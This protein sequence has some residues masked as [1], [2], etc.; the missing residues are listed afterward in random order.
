VDA[1]E[2]ALELLP[3]D[4]RPAALDLVGLASEGGSGGLVDSA[5]L[6]VAVL[7]GQP[8]PWAALGALLGAA[9]WPSVTARA[10]AAVRERL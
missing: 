8:V 9:G 4:E 6:A 10:I 3:E 7:T 5:D 2:A 1:L